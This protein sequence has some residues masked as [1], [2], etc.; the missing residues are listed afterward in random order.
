MMS[1]PHGMSSRIM[2]VQLQLGH[3]HR[4]VLTSAYVPTLMAADDDKEVFYN[5]LDSIIHSVP[6]KHWFLLL[7]DFSAHVCHNTTVWLNSSW[8]ENSY[9]WRHA[10]CM[11]W[12]SP[13]CSSWWPINAKQRPK[14]WHVLELIIMWLFWR[15][16]D[17]S[18][19]SYLVL[20]WPLTGDKIWQAT[21]W[22]N[23]LH[24]FTI[25]STSPLNLQ[26]LLQQFTTCLCFHY[27]WQKSFLVRYIW[28]VT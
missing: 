26:A 12:P 22:G 7:V 11:N 18:H 3:S 28:K 25:L 8:S 13:T 4:I 17:V 1:Q 9:H 10:P 2:S 15:A 6:F 23:M 5:C 24:M 27:E 19:A 14:H 20:A 16:H 21:S